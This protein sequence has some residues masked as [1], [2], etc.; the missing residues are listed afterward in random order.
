MSTS[1]WEPKAARARDESLT[2]VTS[3][4]KSRWCSATISSRKVRSPPQLDFR[5][6]SAGSAAK[7]ECSHLNHSHADLIMCS[8]Q[9]QLAALAIN[10]ELE[11]KIRASAIWISTHKPISKILTSHLESW[12]WINWLISKTDPELRVLHAVW[13]SNQALLCRKTLRCPSSRSSNSTR[14]KLT[15]ALDSLR[16]KSLHQIK[17]NRRD[18]LLGA[19]CRSPVGINLSLRWWANVNSSPSIISQSRWWK[20]G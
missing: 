19:S 12:N 11:Y 9:G 5:Q 20:I 18:K 7:E 1:L 3:N 2:G 10:R 8:A 16:R 4:K 17:S 14:A 15:E 13:A 6:I